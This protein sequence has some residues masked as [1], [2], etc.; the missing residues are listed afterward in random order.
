MNMTDIEY[1]REKV[2]KILVQVTAT[3]G[4]VTRLEDDLEELE[5]DLERTKTHLNIIKG[6]DK[7]LWYVI[8]A[9]VTVA[10]FFISHFI[11]KI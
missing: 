7:T 8:I 5:Y 6:R 4:R 2:D 9:I 3:N 1:I 11:S 10:G